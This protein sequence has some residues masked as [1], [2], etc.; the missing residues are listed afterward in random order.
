MDFFL[1]VVTLLCVGFVMGFLCGASFHKIDGVFL[2]DDQE[3]TTQ[4]WTLDMKIMPEE[5]LKKKQI[6]LDVNVKK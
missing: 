1:L 4:H 2:I 5:I 3:G 6:H